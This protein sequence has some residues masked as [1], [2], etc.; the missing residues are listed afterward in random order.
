MILEDPDPLPQLVML[1]VTVIKSMSYESIVSILTMLILLVFSAL[2]SGSEVAF[3]SLSPGDLE[4]LKQKREKK[5]RSVINLLNK[6]KRLLATILI[7]NNFINVA[8]IMISAFVT[9]DIF[10]F[11]QMPIIGFFV[12]VIVITSF[13]LIFGEIVPKMIANHR[14]MK[15][16]LLMVLPIKILVKL[17]YPFSSVLVKSTNVI[18]KKIV[19]GGK[20][21][22][23]YEISHAIDITSDE[24]LHEKDKNILKGIVHFSDILVKE[25]MTNRTDITA[26][27]AKIP[28]DI[29]L[30]TIVDKGFSRIPVYSG[31]MDNILG[32]LYIKDLLSHISE[33]DFNWKENL[34]QPYYVPE[35]KL[36]RSLLQEFQENKIHIAIVVDEY[37]GTQGIVT[38]EDIIEEIIGEI[39][40]EFDIGDEVLDYEKI[41]DNKY[42]F[43]GKTLINDF[44]KIFN[45]ESNYFD[46][47]KGD[48]DTIAGMI[49]EKIGSLPEKEAKININDFLFVV[50]RVDNRRIIKV[51]VSRDGQK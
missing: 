3:F 18:D 17:F 25:I 33:K 9:H 50:E 28:Y 49:L 35:N 42:S 47:E 27:E 32:I 23:I 8:I 16:S 48:A 44:C 1:L 37:G 13:L 43:E 29:I 6:P 12:E 34:H 24:A 46:E 36:I 14:P 40:D 45:I 30:K 7:S 22:S 10:D 26:F 41:A 11:G 15:F 38:L 39:S 19:K 21:I 20:D 2:V 31:S 4:D 5:N 51:E